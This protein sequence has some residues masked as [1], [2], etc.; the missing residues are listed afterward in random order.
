MVR[1]SRLVCSDAAPIVSEPRH[2][3]LLTYDISEPKIWRQAYKLLLAWG[4]RIQY[5]VFRV[6]ATNR[7]IEE[8]RCRLVEILEST[9][10][11]MIARLCNNCTRKISLDGP[12][13]QPFELDT[14]SHF[15]Q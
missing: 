4:H 6:R 5:S 3:Y 10:R 1:R 2:H 7:E 8:L 12:P 9:D 13:I 14:P 15:L 11:L